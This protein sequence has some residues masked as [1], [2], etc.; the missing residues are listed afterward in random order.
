MVFLTQVDNGEIDIEK[1]IFI[2]FEMSK[3]LATEVNSG[4]LS[5]SSRLLPV[6]LPWEGLLSIDFGENDHLKIDED[7][8][9]GK[10]LPYI[11]DGQKLNN[12]KMIVFPMH[13]LGDQLYLAVALRHLAKLYPS[14]EVGIV[15][16]SL[17]SSEQWYDYIYFDAFYSITGPVVTI[18]E[19]QT[20]DYY[21]ATEHFA[22]L[23]AYKGMYPPEFYL[24][25]FF[26]H[27][28]VHMIK[29]RPD[30]GHSLNIPLSDK[31]EIDSLFNKLIKRSK[32]IVFVS[33]VTTGRVRDIPLAAV[34]EFIELLRKQYTCIVSTYNNQS[35]ETAV[36]ALNNAYI[37]CTNGL[38]KNVDDLIYML[39]RCDAIVTS[40]SGIT[41]LGE[42]LE[43]PTGSV[44]NVV[45]PEE[46]TG[47]Y[48]FSEQMMVEFEIPHICKTPC[49]IH[50]LAPDEICPGM[51][52][53]N[54][55][56]NID[57]VRPYAPCMENFKGEHLFIL[58]EALTEKF[59]Q[60][61]RQ[62]VKTEVDEIIEKNVF[63]KDVYDIIPETT[64][65]ILDFGCNE[66]EL[67]LRLQRDKGC[68]KLYGIEIHDNSEKIFEK[69]LDG[70]WII[71]LGHDDAELDERFKGYFN[72]IILHDV[73]EHLYDPWYVVE[74]LRAYLAPE[75]RIIIVVPNLQYWGI[76][77][78]IVN[79]RF[80]YG[81]GGLMN[82]DHIRWFT[83]NSI[84]E[85]TLMAG[86]TID[87]FV[88]LFPPGTDMAGYNND[89]VKKT[90][91]FPPV[92]KNLSKSSGLFLNFGDDPGKNYYLFLANKILLVCSNS[93][94]PVTA[95]KVSVGGL[96]KR[97]EAMKIDFHCRL[98]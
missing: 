46:R 88:P 18:D 44:F 56:E 40:D 12:K 87:Y 72:Y 77:E 82:E 62:T 74:K 65:K 8:W 59:G 26:H 39:G 28:A 10:G 63:R 80:P 22:H 31:N 89:D 2:S 53:Q 37:I 67:L 17:S 95:E 50:A 6:H 35:L 21:V 90:L 55:M 23:E 38:I 92:E 15:K 13:G 96:Q 61:K 7:E 98:G 76:L 24:K 9:I 34:M 73:V 41:H 32:P 33:S 68:S 52:W 54:K 94:K 49:Y 1:G 79:G 86:Y 25:Y 47:P 66:G 51:R 43:V 75:G 78:Q 69:H 84:I 45:S 57:I 58:L 5:L 4:N 60:K 20:Y 81:G 29:P 3:H 48:Q 14:L 93:D 27:E 19:M 36:N 83:C 16:P 71:D 11:Y 85:L 42:C 91:Q 30:I 70:H 64:E 97:K